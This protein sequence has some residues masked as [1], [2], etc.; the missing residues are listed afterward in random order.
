MAW[1]RLSAQLREGWTEFPKLCSRRCYYVCQGQKKNTK[2]KSGMGRAGGRAQ[3]VW[4]TLLSIALTWKLTWHI[5]ILKELTT[6]EIK[7]PVSLH[8][9]C[10][11]PSLLN[12][13]HPSCHTQKQS[14]EQ[15]CEEC[16]LGKHSCAKRVC[17]GLPCFSP[18]GSPAAYHPPWT[19]TNLNTST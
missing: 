8:L 12:T 17:Q 7:E 14:T 11:L 13:R 1:V 5:C 16:Q 4:K 6:S 19:Q 3:K 18:A 15:C 10:Y 9:I 2:R